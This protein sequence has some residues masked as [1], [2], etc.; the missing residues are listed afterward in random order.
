MPRQEYFPAFDLR[1][2][3]TVEEL[4]WA[5]GG[6]DVTAGKQ[7]EINVFNRDRLEDRKV[8]HSRAFFVVVCT[9][10]VSLQ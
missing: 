10:A 3:S 4:E 9:R 1:D 8:R 2:L 6:L 7:V 5:T